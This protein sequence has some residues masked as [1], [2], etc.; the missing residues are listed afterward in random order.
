MRPY[1]LLTQLDIPWD[2]GLL[3][4]KFSKMRLVGIQ[5][6]NFSKVSKRPLDPLNMLFLKFLFGFGSLF[7][8]KQSPSLNHGWTTSFFETLA[9]WHNKLGTDE[10]LPNLIKRK[11]S[12]KGERKN[13]GQ[14]PR[15][16]QTNSPKEA[17]HKEVRGPL[18]TETSSN[19]LKCTN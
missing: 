11:Q 1:R 6:G 2:Q 9:N 16:R 3:G 10:T 15:S 18:N 5:W 19:R 17:G 14:G 7:I 8:V 12:R 13:K 4:N